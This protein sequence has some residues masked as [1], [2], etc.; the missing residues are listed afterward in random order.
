MLKS[1]CGRNFTVDSPICFTYRPQCSSS[2]LPCLALRIFLFYSYFQDQKCTVPVIRGGNLK[3]SHANLIT[4]PLGAMRLSL[5]SIYH[6]P[7]IQATKFGASTV[8]RF[9]DRRGE[10]PK[11]K[12]WAM[13][14]RPRAVYRGICLALVS[15]LI[16]KILRA[17]VRRNNQKVMIRR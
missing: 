14:P 8:T 5:A 4:P 10:P 2:C 1:C 15:Q 13:R 17:S 6:V 11:F 7:P 12:K 3:V 16:S 9:R